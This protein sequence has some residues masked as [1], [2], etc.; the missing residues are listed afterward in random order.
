MVN[1]PLLWATAANAKA[2]ATTATIKDAEETQ[3]SEVAEG[4]CSRLKAIFAVPK[5]PRCSFHRSRPGGADEA[6]LGYSAARG[7][8]FVTTGN[9]WGT[10]RLSP[11]PGSRR[12]K[13]NLRFP[14]AFTYHG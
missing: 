8:A 2:K 10:S 6:A 7:A 12:V 4:A 13:G 9:A 1:F 14:L 11:R 3:R 5:P